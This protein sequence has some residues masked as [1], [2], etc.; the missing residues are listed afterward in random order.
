MKI[1]RVLNGLNPFAALGEIEV[2]PRLL[3]LHHISL[4]SVTT[5]PP[6]F[7]LPDMLITIKCA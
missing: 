3:T 7:Q 2:F 4:I 1:P 6:N 5:S